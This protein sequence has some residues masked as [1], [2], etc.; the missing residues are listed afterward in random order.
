MPFPS[1]GWCVPV[2]GLTS[3]VSIS[4]IVSSPRSTH[5]TLVNTSDVSPK[6]ETHAQGGRA[7]MRS[8]PVDTSRPGVLRCAVQPEAK[9]SDFRHGRPVDGVPQG[10]L[11][12]LHRA[13]Q[14]KDRFPD[15]QLYANLR[16]YDPGEP[17]LAQQ[18][19]RGFLRALGVT[20]TDVPRTSTTRPR[21]TA[22]RPPR[23]DPASPRP[24]SGPP[25]LDRVPDP[26]RPVRRPPGRPDPRPHQRTPGR[27]RGPTVRVSPAAGRV[28][29]PVPVS[30]WA[31]HGP[32]RG[33]ALAGYGRRGRRSPC[34]GGRRRSPG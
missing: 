4:D 3:L 30:P 5:S 1:H 34:P 10:A 6:L 2:F 7:P 26:A 16:G 31:P 32:A 17:V 9:I 25:P 33:A 24:R 8:I 22:R 29:V 18:G 27:D 12:A 11:R 20:A 28:R 13:H 15:G 19:L 14:A 21:S 23:A